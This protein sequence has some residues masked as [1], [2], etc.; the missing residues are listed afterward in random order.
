MRSP[1]A[2]LID[3]LVWSRLSQFW[4]RTMDVSDRDSLSTVYEAMFKVLD[5]EY[6]RL[7]QINLAKSIVTCPIFTQR[8]WLRLDLN[9]YNE[10]RAWLRF[11]TN[12]I[13][14]VGSGTGSG[15]TGSGGTGSSTADSVC[16]TPPTNHAKH[17]HLN[18]PFTINPLLADPER[19]T[20]NLHFPVILPLI[21]VYRMTVDGTGR[22]VGTRLVPERDLEVLPD[23]TSMRIVTAAANEQFEV[24]AA[25]DL[26]GAAYEDM[27]PALFQA[28]TFLGPNV[29]AVPSAFDNGLPVHV[30]VVRNPPPGSGAGISV[31]NTSTF[32]SQRYFIP[33]TGDAATG[34]AHGTAGR[35]VIPVSFAISP[36]DVVFVFSLEPGDFD[37]LHRHTTSS[38]YLDTG[39][40]NPLGTLSFPAPSAITRGIFGSVDSFGHRLQ[41]FVAG[42]LVSPNEYSF[43]LATNAFTVRVPLT[44]A[45][46]LAIDVRYTEEN[47]AAAENFTGLHNH[48]N[49]YLERAVVSQE[50]ATFDDGGDF[51][52]DGVFD[53]TADA[54]IVTIDF[55][56]SLTSLAVFVDGVLARSGVEYTASILPD[57][58]TQIFFAFDV[59]GRSILVD[60]LRESAL[61]VFG[62]ADLL[63]GASYSFTANT[64]SG[65]LNDLKN[66]IPAFEAAYGSKVSNLAALI[67][68]A[69]VAAAGGNPMLTLF[70]DEHP[71]Y[72]SLGVDAA[73]QPLTAIDARNL[74]SSDTRLVDIPFMVDHVQ[75]PTVRVE[76]GTDYR[77]VDGVITTSLD[78]LASRGA[79]DEN[80]GV[81]WCPL[82]VLDESMLAKNFGAPLGDVRGK[83]SLDYRDSLEANLRLR[84]SGATVADIAQSAAIM[85][86]SRQ[87]QQDGT[88]RSITERT[89]GRVVTLVN[90]AGTQQQLES[91]PATSTP[92]E[93]G[94]RVIPGQSLLVPLVF[95][96]RLSS[97]VKWTGRS[98]VLLED[99]ISARAGD[100]ARLLLAY[101]GDL[102]GEK[103]WVQFDILSVSTEAVFGGVSTTLVFRQSTNLVATTDSEMDIRR[104]AGSP[105]SSL[106][107]TVVDV[108]SRTVLVV[109]TEAEEFTVPLGTPLGYTV[110]DRV[111]RGAPVIPTLARFYDDVSRPGWHWLTPSQLALDWDHLVRDNAT[112]VRRDGLTDVRTAAISPGPNGYALAA[113]TPAYPS[114]ARGSLVSVTY[115]D[116]V[117]TKEFRVIGSDGPTVLLFPNAG[118][119]INGT[120]TFAVTPA[121][122]GTTGK[123]FFQVPLLIKPQATLQFA[124]RAG[125]VSLALTG[126]ATFPER[127][128]VRILPVGGGAIDVEYFAR[129]ADR[130]YNL[131]WPQSYPALT[132]STGTVHPE[133]PAG[134]AVLGIWSYTAK[135]INPAFISLV[136]QRV[137]RDSGSLSGIPE[138]TAS[139]AD[140]YYD[141]FKRTS[142][143]LETRSVAKP[144][145]LREV[146]SEVLPP[147]VTV[148]IQ[149]QQ[150]VVDP[151]LVQST[152]GSFA[153]DQ[154]ATYHPMTLV[155]T[156]PQ[157]AIIA[158]TLSLPA[159][160]I[161]VVFAVAVADPDDAT[162]HA[163]LWEIRVI[164]G[165]PSVAV[166]DPTGASSR[167]TGL[168]VGGQYLCSVTA[169][170][171]FGR[172]RSTSATV[173]VGA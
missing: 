125:Q 96:G 141:I 133:L 59:A 73:N 111:S 115:D 127:G 56:V 92:P 60:F 123:D 28:T 147:G 161:E 36:S 97:L 132:D 137:V 44:F 173:L 155:L 158:D 159:S 62:G 153:D 90:L 42:K 58:R 49:C 83:S 6:V 154:V 10:L 119:I 69:R 24:S 108:S 77:V 170:N 157:G 145:A 109:A 87:F 79:T 122:A 16:L 27:R 91:I 156:S 64:L 47:R 82:V 45:T 74:E 110:G 1:Q 168:E 146:L 32:S 112:S 103:T 33:Y 144:E 101:P 167:F 120:A 46:Q 102:D 37:T 5:A 15:G 21:E 38:F 3:E 89:V 129:T 136:Q 139:N 163:L 61:Y 54:N 164:R 121:T 128:Q 118:E 26:S 25:F 65:T 95:S 152:E 72:I 41:L 71:E 88:V 50:Y 172:S 113:V 138:I 40:A 4:S 13:G 134:T 94:S 105:Y 31:T 29:I 17:W 48:Y 23:G 150:V 18:F 114:P 75:N 86:G 124:H 53:D 52:D 9:R 99:L 148:V 22:K 76:R 30:L 35:V 12:G 106:E 78:L 66:L 84:Y 11:L 8:R 14:G 116:G 98:V 2:E 34:A 140:Q 7:G 135:Q 51:D 68:A 19:R 143:V 55:A 80:P 160:A 107:G 149:G 93:V 165:S 57:G 70:F 126:L 39:N 81:W 20:I 100:V 63:G 130:L 85:L 151:Y 169:T 166:V 142:A 131:V 171:Q 117:R 43:N 67:D 162:P 104:D